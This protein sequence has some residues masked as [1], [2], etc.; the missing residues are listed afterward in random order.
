MNTDADIAWNVASEQV[1]WWRLHNFSTN[2]AMLALGY[3]VRY[4]IW[5]EVLFAC[6]FVWMQMRGA[7]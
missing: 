7:K 5:G 2:E 6:A 4:A 1:L 3:C